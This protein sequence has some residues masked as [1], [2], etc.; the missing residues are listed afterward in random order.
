VD[1]SALTKLLVDFLERP[2]T[3]LLEDVGSAAALAKLFRR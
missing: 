3:T 2:P 1:I